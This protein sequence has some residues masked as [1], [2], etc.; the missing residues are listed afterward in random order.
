MNK[1]TNE[2]TEKTDEDCRVENLKHSPPCNIKKLNESMCLLLMQLTQ[3]W[4]HEK[5]VA[6]LHSSECLQHVWY[7]EARLTKAKTAMM[8]K[9]HQ[10]CLSN[11]QR[12]KRR[13]QVSESLRLY[14]LLCSHFKDY[15]KV[16]KVC[17]YVWS[18]HTWV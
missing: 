10:H 6:A 3:K 7:D 13:I 14:S 8:K 15:C 2:D 5:F 11:W 17:C 18:S 4:S 9:I 12:K 1:S 16:E